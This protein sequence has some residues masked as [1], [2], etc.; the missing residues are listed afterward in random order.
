MDAYVTECVHAGIAAADVICCSRLGKH[1]IGE[2]HQEAVDLL[3]QADRDLAKDL[4]TLLKMKTSSGYSDLPTSTKRH[5]QASRA[6]KR[7]VDAAMQE[8]RT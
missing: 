1:A 3:A 4:S 2:N 6:M 5:A 8:V 7:L